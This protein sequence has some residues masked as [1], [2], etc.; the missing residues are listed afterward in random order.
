MALDSLISSFYGIKFH[1]NP[2]ITFE[3]G[4]KTYRGR[5]LQQE[6]SEELLRSIHFFNHKRDLRSPLVLPLHD[7]P[8]L[9]VHST[10][11]EVLSHG[12]ARVYVPKGPW[13]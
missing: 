7:T 6:F 13:T 9:L 1:K 3:F 4:L 10:A 5:W 12:C 8:Y 11:G 2:K